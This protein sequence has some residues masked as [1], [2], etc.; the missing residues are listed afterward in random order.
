MGNVLICQNIPDIEPDLE[1]GQTT[2]QSANADSFVY[3]GTSA[4]DLGYDRGYEEGYA[5][6]S[7][8]NE[9]Y[10]KQYL[11]LLNRMDHPESDTTIFKELV[12]DYSRMF[13]KYQY[14][15][16]E[17]LDSTNTA[18][19]STL[20]TAMIETVQ[21]IKRLMLS[22]YTFNKAWIFAYDDEMMPH[23][24]MQDFMQRPTN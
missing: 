1:A 3:K 17:N 9:D 10:K 16:T 14:Y 5:D 24:F 8:E 7:A 22:G 2:A 23:Q 21:S 18:A 20:R 12:A 15:A 13:N 6:S 19:L 4:Y 11:D